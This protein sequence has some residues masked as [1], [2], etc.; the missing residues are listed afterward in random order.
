MLDNMKKLVLLIILI[1][2][3]LALFS[4]DNAKSEWTKLKDYGV[5]MV[6]KGHVKVFESLTQYDNLNISDSV[7]DARW[8]GN[9][10]IIYLKDGSIR[11]YTSL[12]QYNSIK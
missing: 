10:I 2:C 4:Q 1:L 7:K 11:K 9:T 12:T 8:S 3:A 6:D 5:V